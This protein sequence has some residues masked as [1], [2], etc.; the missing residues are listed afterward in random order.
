MV[1]GKHEAASASGWMKMVADWG[2]CCTL[3]F[4]P[5]CSSCSLLLMHSTSPCPMV[6]PWV[7]HLILYLPVH[8]PCFAA[9]NKEEGRQDYK[10]HWEVKGVTAE[11]KR[12]WRAEMKQSLTTLFLQMAVEAFQ[13][14]KVFQIPI[15]I[16]PRGNQR[17]SVSKNAVL[18][19]SVQIF[20]FI[21]KA[22]IKVLPPNKFHVCSLRILVMDRKSRTFIS[23]IFSFNPPFAQ[24][25]CRLA[26]DMAIERTCLNYDLQTFALVLSTFHWWVFMG[27]SYLH[28]WH[29]WHR[30]EWLNLP[31]NQ[32][33]SCT[34]Y[35]PDHLA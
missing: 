13:A 27:Y 33:L 23:L 35:G 12:G 9:A 19:L 30:T 24:R 2:W 21:P 10:G 32:R 15:N 26:V 14:E 17:A 6:G 16:L 1:R 25:T 22:L 18:C 11:G 31:F 28:L 8:F 3:D 20:P 34:G 7:D 5:P 29:C 4:L